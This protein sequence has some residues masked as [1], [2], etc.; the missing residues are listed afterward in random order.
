MR[1]RRHDGVAGGRGCGVPR[2]GAPHPSRPGPSS[3]TLLG[4]LLPAEVRVV[5]VHRDVA[6]VED[7]ADP[8]ELAVVAAARPERRREFLTGRWCAR[9]ALHLLGGPAE[10]VLPGPRRAPVWPAGVVGSITHCAGHR[11]AAVARCEDLAALG[12]DATPHEPL[13]PRVLHVVADAAEREHLARLA[14]AV[15]DVHVD[16]VLFSAKE[17]LIKA[18]S[19]LEKDW[20]GFNGFHVRLH[21][22]GTFTA[23]VRTAGPVRT[24]TGRWR[25]DGE[26]AGTAVAVPAAP[27]GRCGGLVV[28]CASS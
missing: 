25:A 16:R 18:W 10:P 12:V 8:R 21:E 19:A 15:P 17:S 6:G 3:G 11:A 13:P 26:L 9:R 22:D 4:V 23:E 24:A 7:G 14:A 5:E 1:D 20:P 27:R 28:W 2:T